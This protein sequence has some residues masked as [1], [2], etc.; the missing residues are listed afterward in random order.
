MIKL[1]LAKLTLYRITLAPARKPYRI[2]V[3]FTHNNGDFGEISVRDGSLFLLRVGWKMSGSHGNISYKRLLLQTIF[4]VSPSS[5]KHF[6][7]YLHTIYFSVYSLCK[8][9]ISKFSNPYHPPPC[10][11]QK[12]KNKINNGLSVKEWSC[13]APKSHISWVT[14]TYWILGVQSEL[15]MVSARKAIRYGVHKHSLFLSPIKDLRHI[16]AF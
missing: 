1:M 15:L 12:K 16:A 8:Q 2:G 6:I 13:A 14:I 10:Y 9:F 5:C 11:R 4:S 7:F 3:L